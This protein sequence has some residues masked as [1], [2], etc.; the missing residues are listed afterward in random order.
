MIELEER[1][2][3]TGERTFM[4]MKFDNHVSVGHIITTVL[5]A[6]AII[7]WRADTDNRL[8][9]LEKQDQVFENEV[10]TFRNDY[11]ADL[12]EIRQL[13]QQISDKM[14]KKADK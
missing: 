14:D 3:T 8:N 5:I 12:R 4:G 10:Q 6:V 2:M 9:N 7:T 13:F 11:K 1:K